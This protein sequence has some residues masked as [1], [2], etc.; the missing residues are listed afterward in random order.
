MSENFLIPKEH[1]LA[2]LG[3]FIPD[4]AESWF[5]KVITNK[6]ELILPPKPEM[7]ND[8][9]ALNVKYQALNYLQ[10]MEG[11]KYHVTRQTHE[12]VL[13]LIIFCS[14]PIRKF[15][16]KNKYLKAIQY[17]EDFERY[18]D[19][20]KVLKDKNEN[21]IEE[22]IKKDWPKAWYEKNRDKGLFLFKEVIG[23]Q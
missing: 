2:I 5:V 8:L 11:F 1:F 19:E 18:L 4:E 7:A 23:C 15:L 10:S 3:S 16:F 6:N 17:L 21:L 20:C 22:S 13:G 12:E 14:S 9:K